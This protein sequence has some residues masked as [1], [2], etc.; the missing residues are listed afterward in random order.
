MSTKK[1]QELIQAMPPDRRVKL[2]QNFAEAIAGMPLDQ[3]RKAQQMTQ[4]NVAT[5]LGQSGRGF[6]D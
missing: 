1:F 6:K 4:V 3:L 5:V 2:E